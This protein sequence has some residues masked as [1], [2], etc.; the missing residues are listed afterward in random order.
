[1]QKKEIFSITDNEEVTTNYI[2]CE[3][4]TAELSCLD[5]KI[6]ILSANYGRTG[7]EKCSGAKSTTTTGCAVSN[8]LQIVQ[9]QCQGQSNCQIEAINSVFGDPCVGTYKYLNITAYCGTC[10]LYKK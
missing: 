4:K 3:R 7:P 1:M 8:S 2:T 6:N 9:A 10:V 5:G